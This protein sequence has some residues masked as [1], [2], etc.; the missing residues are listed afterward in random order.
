M[1]RRSAH[2][3]LLPAI[4]L[5]GALALVFVSAR[6]SRPPAPIA[7]YSM[8][9]GPTIVLV[10]GLGSRIEHWLPVARKLARTHR[11]VLAELPGH[12]E[13]AMTEPLTLE[14]A[15][16]ALEG[17]L[18]RETREPVTLVGHSVGGLVAAK[19]AL[20]RPR[21]VR[22]LVLIETSLKPAMDERE[23]LGLL[24][25]LDHD[26]RGLVE[27]A[28]TSFGS[29]SVQGRRL[30]D[31]AEAQDPKNL[32]P[33]IRL[34][35]TADLSAAAGELRLPVVAAL[36]D[37]TWPRDESWP[38][39]AKELGYERIPQVE[40]VRFEGTGHFVMLDRPTDVA[41]LIARVA[42]GEG[43]VVGASKSSH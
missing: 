29:D 22:A 32:K 1:T 38:A 5:F 6:S 30:A 28:Y 11:V 36:S 2:S 20:D 12:G 42:G 39:C 37:R 19:L 27:G 3:L 24:D 8:G 14:R 4:V 43:E 16:A 23:R 15:A 31:E 35:L 21:L 7:S 25:Q 10:H 34:A 17:T 26:Y 18:A 40:P 13:S 9:H 33:W 41:R